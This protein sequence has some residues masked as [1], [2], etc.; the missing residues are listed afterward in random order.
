MKRSIVRPYLSLVEPGEPSDPPAGG[1]GGD[2][3]PPKPPNDPPA[4]NEPPKPSDVPPSGPTINEHGYPENTPIKEMSPEHQ[5]NYWKYHSRKNENLLKSSVSKEEH[6]RVKLELDN[7]KRAALPEAERVQA[8]AQ[9]AAK[10]AALTALAP[11]LIRAEIRAATAGKVT[12]QQID[13]ALEFVDERKFLD[14]NGDVDPDKVTRYASGLLPSEPPPPDMSG[15]RAGGST[16][17]RGDG[18]ASTSV[19]AAR[20]AAL[21]ELRSKNRK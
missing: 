17:G 16:S 8:D 18:A 21:E 20:E 9:A 3:T 15:W 5:V 12:A 4:G 7:I 2:P 10:K 6:D 1:S 13:E 14:Q 19:A 11:K